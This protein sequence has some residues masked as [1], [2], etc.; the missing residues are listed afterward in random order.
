M[1]KE[2]RRGR[3]PKGRKKIEKKN[4]K[5]EEN[6]KGKEKTQR[7]EREKNKERKETTGEKEGEKKKTTEEM[8]S[9]TKKMKER[10]RENQKRK[11][12]RRKK[13]HNEGRRDIEES[14]G[15]GGTVVGVGSSGGVRGV[16]EGVR[17][18]GAPVVCSAPFAVVATWSRCSSGREGAGSVCGGALVLFYCVTA[19]SERVAWAR[20][21]VHSG[22]WSVEGVCH[23]SVLV[24]HIWRG[25]V[26]WVSVGGWG[27]EQR[28][29]EGGWWCG[30]M[31]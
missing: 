3:N 28:V 24:M 21:R 27:V 5:E 30:D 25:V 11:P 8:G 14:L 6:R 26:A 13:I 19:D 20:G 23:V 1:N 12:T 2:Y 31:V 4:K 17:Y 22:C 7:G 18:V 9:D 29:G 10:K 16:E 15:L